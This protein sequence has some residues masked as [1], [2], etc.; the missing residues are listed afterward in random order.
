[1]KMTYIY[2]LK[3]YKIISLVLYE[4]HNLS[5]KKVTVT[6]VDLSLPTYMG[7]NPR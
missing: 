4:K 7:A 1:M 2:W 3:S 5:K 6:Q